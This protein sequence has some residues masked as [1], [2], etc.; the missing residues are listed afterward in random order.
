MSEWLTCLVCGQQY[1][2]ITECPGIARGAHTITARPIFASPSYAES[3][4]RGKA[5]ESVVAAEPEAALLDLIPF[6]LLR[7]QGGPE[8]PTIAQQILQRVALMRQANELHQLLCWNPEQ[9][10]SLAMFAIDAK[11][12]LR[13]ALAERDALRE[14]LEKYGDHKGDCT[15]CPRVIAGFTYG[16]ALPPA[17]CS[18]GLDTA[19][20][21]HP[22][23]E[24]PKP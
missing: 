9:L 15:K 18:C 21:A 19:L 23:P 24:A 22:A 12:Q 1:E 3:V 8:R 10:E 2:T 14:A 11:G 6:G 16:D 7:W 20:A 13:A 17:P 5:M 4:A